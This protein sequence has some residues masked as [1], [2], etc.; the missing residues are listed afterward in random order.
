[1]SRMCARKDPKDNKDPK[2]KGAL[3]S[4]LSLMSLSAGYDEIGPE[5]HRPGLLLATPGGEQTA[6]TASRGSR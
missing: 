5:G 3:L 4:L 6:A 1:M 2:D